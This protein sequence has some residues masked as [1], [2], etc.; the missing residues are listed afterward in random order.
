[1]FAAVLCTGAKMNKFSVIAWIFVGLFFL[2]ACKQGE[3]GVCQ[4]KR[5]CEGELI[6][7]NLTKRC[8]RPGG[9]RIEADAAPEE[10]DAPPVDASVIDAMVE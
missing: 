8:G 6:C 3:G 4:V 1:V 9:G 7:I 10:P 5:D 2:G